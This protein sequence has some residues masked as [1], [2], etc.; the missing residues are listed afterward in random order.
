M[1]GRMEGRPAGFC[2]LHLEA[3][4]GKIERIDKRINGPDRIVLSNPVI[5]AFGQKCRLSPVS[6]LNVALH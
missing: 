4:L 5:E 3:K 2:W 6:P 1:N